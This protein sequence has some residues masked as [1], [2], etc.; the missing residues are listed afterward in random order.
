MESINKQIQVNLP[1]QNFHCLVEPINDNQ[2]REVIEYRVPIEVDYLFFHLLCRDHD[3]EINLATLYAEFRA[4]FGP[5]GNYFDSWKGAFS[6]AFKIEILKDNEVIPYALIVSNMRSSVEFRFY[7]VI[8]ASDTQ[9]EKHRIYPPFPNELSAANMNAVSAFL[10]SYAKTVY[11]VAKIEQNDF[12]KAI[13]SNLILFGYRQ[14]KFFVTQ[15]KTEEEFEVDYR[16]FSGREE[17]HG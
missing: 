5:S 14:Q 6:F 2:L 16:L 7:K 15:Y 9:F 12:T 11:Q 13:Q 3:N 8:S 10:C 1:T 17:K 4:V